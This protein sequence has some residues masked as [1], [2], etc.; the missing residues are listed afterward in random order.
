[1]VLGEALGLLLLWG[2]DQQQIH[3]N[4][5]KCCFSCSLSWSERKGR[6]LPGLP[7]EPPARGLP[8]ALTLGLPRISLEP[9]HNFSP[10]L[11]VA[12]MSDAEAW[13]SPCCGPHTTVG[14]RVWGQG[15]KC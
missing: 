6:R 12:V 3:N 2:L 11:C 13:L 8:H 15:S 10:V 4:P 14:V 7:A 9:Q 5:T 1:M